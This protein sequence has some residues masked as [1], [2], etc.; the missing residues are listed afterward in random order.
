MIP[1]PMIRMQIMRADYEKH[2]W[3]NALERLKKGELDDN[4]LKYP[5]LRNRLTGLKTVEISKLISTS[6]FVIG[7]FS[8]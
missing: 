5:S 4:D 6:F 3:K 7:N 8:S 1:D 2:R